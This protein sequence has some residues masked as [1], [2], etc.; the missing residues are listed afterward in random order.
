MSETRSTSDPIEQLVAACR[1]ALGFVQDSKAKA[2]ATIDKRSDQEVRIERALEVL[3]SETVPRKGR[4]RVIS[5]EA[6]QR[7]RSA[8]PGSLV[9]KACGNHFAS[10]AHKEACKAAVGKNG[11]HPLV[12]SAV[13]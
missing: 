11:L 9:C 1:Q 8:A 5:D 10:N 12:E 7:L 13:S 4:Q 6:R 3:T 2:A